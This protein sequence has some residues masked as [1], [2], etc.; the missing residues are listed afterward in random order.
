MESV[1]H[2]V[3]PLRVG[4][5]KMKKRRELDALVAHSLAKRACNAKRQAGNGVTSQ[6]QLL[7]Q[8]TDD[9]EDSTWV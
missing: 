1:G 8:S 2:V 7:S 9:Q 4:G 6:D 3:V 5:K